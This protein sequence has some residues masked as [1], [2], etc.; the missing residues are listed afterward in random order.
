LIKGII[1]FIFI[2]KNRYYIV[3]WKTNWLGT[4]LEAY[5]QENMKQSILEHR[6]DLQAKIY[7]EAL[8]RYLNI[9][10]ARPFEEC[11]GGTFYLYLRGMTKGT[12]S[13]IYSD[14]KT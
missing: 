14:F 5:S 3:D 7:Q 1:D 12:F 10:D 9:I 2:Y 4:S 11:Y 8:R 13:G 6:Y